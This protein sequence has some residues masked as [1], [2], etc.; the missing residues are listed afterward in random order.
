MEDLYKGII[1]IAIRD[2]FESNTDEDKHNRDISWRWFNYTEGHYDDRYVTFLDACDLAGFNSWQWKEIARRVYNELISKEQYLKWESEAE[3]RII[4]FP[5]LLTFI[6][7]PMNPAH[8]AVR[9]FH[10]LEE[11]NLYNAML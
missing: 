10:T 3:E 6:D 8:S 9:K 11:A 7:L 2:L 4:K 5:T 1:K